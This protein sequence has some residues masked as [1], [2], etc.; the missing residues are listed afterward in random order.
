MKEILKALNQIGKEEPVIYAKR[1]LIRDRVVL[2]SGFGDALG[3]KEEFLPLPNGACN[4]TVAS[5]TAGPSTPP[6][7][8]QIMEAKDAIIT[9]NSKACTPYTFSCSHNVNIDNEYYMIKITS[10][11]RVGHLSVSYQCI[12]S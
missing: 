5:S 11:E 2:N 8:I 6:H 4:V 7:Q 1:D 10:D 3:L 9:R 12:R